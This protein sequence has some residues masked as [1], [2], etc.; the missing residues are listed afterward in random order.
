MKRKRN[1]A[2]LLLL[3]SYVLG[4][5]RGF[6]AVWRDGDPQPWLV[7][8]MPVSALPEADQDA[9]EHGIRLPDDMPLAQAL[10]DYCS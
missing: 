2:C 1:L 9:L 3:L 10:E 7:T 6:V 5:S 8:D 4:S